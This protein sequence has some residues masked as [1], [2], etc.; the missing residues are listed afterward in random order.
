MRL[1]LKPRHLQLL[2]A[3]DEY[4]SLARVADAVHITQPAVSKSLA[5]IERMLEV[6]LFERGPRGLVPTIYGECVVRH[7]R[8]LLLGFR[9][10]REELQALRSGGAGTLTIAVLPTA[11][12]RLVPRAVLRL[13]ERAP[14]SIV[15]LREGTVVDMLAELRGERVDVVIGALPRDIRE[16][17]LQSLVVLEGD[18]V[19]C[20]CGPQHPLA[21]S[22]RLDWPALAAYPWIFP[23]ATTAVH[24][25]LQDWLE[26]QGLALPADRIESVCV[27]ANLT[28]LQES[29]CVAFF[30]RDNAEH[31]ARQGLLSILPLALPD[32]SGPV[33]ALWLR[34]KPISPALRAL[35]DALED[36]A[37]QARRG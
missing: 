35:L 32:L 14:G 34:N 19:L 22:E 36:V 13:K 1:D 2:V 7:A 31:L 33:G 6:S 18:P 29:T 37:A 28:L 4:R 21:R 8:G 15:I 27:A 10:A 16:P 17:G 3:L 25:P 20:V 23:P 11:V 5:E 24:L 30:S 9:R 26:Q 12:T